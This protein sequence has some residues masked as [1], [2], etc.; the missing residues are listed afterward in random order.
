MTTKE[1]EMK[2]S[3]RAPPLDATSRL[4][5]PRLY[6]RRRCDRG[7]ASCR[8]NRPGYWKSQSFTGGSLDVRHH[9]VV[10]VMSSSPHNL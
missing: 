3:K 8:S 6:P 7:A 9:P 4:N 10:H 5:L 1:Q 2:I